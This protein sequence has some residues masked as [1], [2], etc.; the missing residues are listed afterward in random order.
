MPTVI[1]SLIVEV[2][3]DPSKFTKGQKEAVKSFSDAKDSAKK[4]GND[5]EDVG[6]RSAEF[7]GVLQTRLIAVAGVVAGGLGLEKLAVQMTKQDAAT[8]RLAYTLNTT[9]QQLDKWRNAAFLVGGTQ[10]GVTS[11]ISHLN[12]EYQNFKIHGTSEIIPYLRALGTSFED[13]AGH[14]KPFE[15]VMREI[16]ARVSSMNPAEARVWLQ[17]IGA[18]EGSINLLIKGTGALDEY[19]KKAEQFGTLTPQQAENARKLAESYNSLS[20][21]MTEWSRTVLNALTPALVKVQ[22]FFAKS[23]SERGDI[24]KTSLFGRLMSYFHMY[25]DANRPADQP[26]SPVT[27]A[28]PFPSR[29]SRLDYYRK[30]AAERGFDPKVVEGVFRGEGFGGYVGDAGSSFG[31]FQL[32]YGGVA[33]G[34][35]AVSGLG[36]TFTKKTGLNARDSSTWKQQFEFVLDQA[37]SGGWSPWHGWNGSPWQ[38]VPRGNASTS[39]DVRISNI[40]IYPPNGDSDT[41]AASIGPAIKRNSLSFQGQ[42]GN[43]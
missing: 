26:A 35:N 17:S 16:S 10:E 9:T 30:R 25:P 1:D 32:H 28:S 19:L 6:K 4:V 42:G 27:G 15:Q 20:L 31:D 24:P 34:G 36:D 8:G 38:G 18:D 11:F 7:L 29:E 5:I 21:A 33:G 40:N 22:E 14:A 41:I 43:Q 12:N 13:S 23:I 39:S 3:L 37:S 2:G